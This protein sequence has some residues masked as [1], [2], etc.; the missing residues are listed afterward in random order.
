MLS[1]V[2]FPDDGLVTDAD[3]LVTDL[4][5]EAALL[6]GLLAE[7]VGLLAAVCLATVNAA[8]V[9]CLA[10]L[11][12]VKLATT[13]DTVEEDPLPAVLER[14]AAVGLLD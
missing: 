1:E 3:G 6:S 5:T 14:G 7:V 2:C 8:E 13:L 11:E 4:V 9:F 12:I 10:W